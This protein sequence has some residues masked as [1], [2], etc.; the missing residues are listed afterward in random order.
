LN[1]DLKAYLKSNFGILNFLQHF[2]RVVEQK[3]HKELKVEYNSRQKFP[4][5][6]LK[7][8]PLLKHE[9]QMYTPVDMGMSSNDDLT[10]VQ[11][12][13]QLSPQA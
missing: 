4:T 5:L 13:F 9:T 1:G 3:Q 6:G 12:S 11:A 10:L 2:E 8:S 7:N